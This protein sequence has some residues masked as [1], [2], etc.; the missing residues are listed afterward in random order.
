M[1][2]LLITGGTVLSTIVPPELPDMMN[3]TL[4]GIEVQSTNVVCRN[5]WGT[6]M[7]PT[8]EGSY[9]LIAVPEAPFI[10]QSL[11]QPPNSP[12]GFDFP[13]FRPGAKGAAVVA[14]PKSAVPEPDVP[15]VVGE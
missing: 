9:S 1:I 2:P 3:H 10:A 4:S 8:G 14:E 15:V 13:E 6:P 5:R 11:I 7:M 12:K